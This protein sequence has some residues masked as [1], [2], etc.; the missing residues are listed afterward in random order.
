MTFVAIGGA[1]GSVL[2][3]LLTK[4]IGVTDSGF[5][6]ATLTVNIVGSFVLGAL[7]GLVAEKLSVD[8]RTGLFVGVLGGFTTYST[9][10]FESVALIRDGLTG[11]AVTYVVVSVVV[12][13]G[14][15]WVGLML[16]DLVHAG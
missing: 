3:H 13:I 1:V 9:F 4:R 5:P 6:L 11:P 7:I 8:V 16:G 2:R 15:A 10:A 12:G 14:A